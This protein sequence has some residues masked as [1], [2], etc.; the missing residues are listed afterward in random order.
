MDYDTGVDLLQG[1]LVE[2][3]VRQLDHL[4]QLRHS[5]GCA[6]RCSCGI[7][8]DV[9]MLLDRARRLMGHYDKEPY[10]DSD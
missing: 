7:D 9:W 3:W 10:E 2:E 6:P 1:D 4:K 8:V 5:D